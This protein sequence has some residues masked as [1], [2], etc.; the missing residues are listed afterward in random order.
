M[1]LRNNKKSDKLK[2]LVY[3][4]TNGGIDN[5]DAIAYLND[6]VYYLQFSGIRRLKKDPRTLVFDGRR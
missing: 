5:N 2:L 6:G 1:E 4:F 3:I